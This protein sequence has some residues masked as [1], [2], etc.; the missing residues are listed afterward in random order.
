MRSSLRSKASSSPSWIWSGSSAE[1]FVEAS[2]DVVIAANVVHANRDLQLSLE[3]LQRVLAPDGRLVLLEGVLPQRFGDLTVGLLEGWWA[4]ADDRTYALV[5][6]GAWIRHLERTGYAAT[7]ITPRA[8][9][10]R[11]SISRRS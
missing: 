2:Y 6:R 11:F 5:D 7:A 4:F 9:S 1:G 10:A 8:A 3:R